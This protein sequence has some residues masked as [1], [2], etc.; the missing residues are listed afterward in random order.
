MQ[1]LG[2]RCRPLKHAK[3]QSLKFFADMVL[4]TRLLHSVC[5]HASFRLK[6]DGLV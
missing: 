2:Q 4:S 1:N 6:R 5:T 3:A